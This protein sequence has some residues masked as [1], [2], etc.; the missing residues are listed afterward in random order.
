MDKKLQ[1]TKYLTMNKKRVIEEKSKDLKRRQM[2]KKTIQKWLS[3]LEKNYYVRKNKYNVYSLTTKGI[4]EQIF[5]ETYGKVLFDSMTKT[6]LTG[7]INEKVSEC[8]KCMG[9]YL[10]CVFTENMWNTSMQRNKHGWIN[11]VINP[12]MMFEWFSNEFESYKQ[13]NINP[14]FVKYHNLFIESHKRYY[15]DIYF[16]LHD[17]YIEA[18]KKR[19]KELEEKL[20]IGYKS[21]SA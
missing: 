13:L 15:S 21:D 5:G 2:S 16:G 7:N 8:V 18:L 11:D 4:S 1:L 10:F 20:G 6:P 14:E 12:S 3:C 19:A 17:R 9:M